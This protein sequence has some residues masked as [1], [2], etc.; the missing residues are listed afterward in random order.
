ML[1]EQPEYNLLFRWFVDL[2]MDELVWMPTVFSQNR[3]RLW[4]GDIAERFFEEVLT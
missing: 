1:I 2:N 4:E 3:E